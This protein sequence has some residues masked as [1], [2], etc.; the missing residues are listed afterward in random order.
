MRRHQAAHDRGRRCL[1]ADATPLAGTARPRVRERRAKGREMH[2]SAV[3]GRGRRHRHASAREDTWAATWAAALGPERRNGR[4]RS[5]D[6]SARFQ[7]SSAVGRRVRSGSAAASGRHL[8]GLHGVVLERGDAVA[9]GVAAEGV[10][11]GASAVRLARAI[12]HSEKRQWRHGA[13]SVPT[14]RRI[15]CRQAPPGIHARPAGC[16]GDVRARGL[17][18]F[19]AGIHARLAV[20][21][22]DVR[23]S[24]TQG[25]ALAAAGHSLR[26]PDQCRQ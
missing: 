1:A 17:H 26:W 16:H 12:Q 2:S 14:I 10:K 22:G 4:G 6:R 18:D 9:E 25:F 5:A 7:R 21:Q 19:L 24:S 23:A 11:A 15:R 3:R 13:V 20:C 8:A